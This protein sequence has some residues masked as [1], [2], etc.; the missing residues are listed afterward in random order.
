MDLSR[1]RAIFASVC[2]GLLAIAAS[3]AIG[4]D[5]S[6]PTTVTSERD[7]ERLR[8]AQGLTLQWIGWDRRGNV[9]VARDPDGVWRIN[10][11]QRG[12]GGR[13]AVD[14][15]IT[16]IGE[17]Y[18]LLDGR[19]V[20]SGTPDRDRLCVEDK[21]WR[22]AVTQERGYYRLREFEWCDGLTDYVDIYFAPRLKG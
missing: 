8:T 21:V 17:D 22:F 15:T 18:F 7:A 12:D 13:L 5:A 9:H 1:K 10:G 3:P 6:S 19:I 2:G 4:E 16:E 20:I 14:G 11:T